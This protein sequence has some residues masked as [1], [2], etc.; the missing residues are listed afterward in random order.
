MY[1]V[2]MRY[3]NGYDYKFIPVLILNESKNRNIM[4]A[5]IGIK[6]YKGKLLSTHLKV[7]QF[8]RERPNS[9]ILLDNIIT[10]DKRS[11]CGF[12]GILDKKQIKDVNK[13]LLTAFGII[14]RCL[15]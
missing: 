1:Y 5:P 2:P 10:I 7:K 12:I 6:D 3:Y 14:N 8:N 11:L 13:C 15:F 4:V 9:I